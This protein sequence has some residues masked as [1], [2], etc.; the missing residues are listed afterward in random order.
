[1]GLPA[2]AADSLT[3]LPSPR[4]GSK[5]KVA[6]D[7]SKG[8]GKGESKGKEAPPV[9]PFAG[10]SGE[11]SSSSGGGRMAAAL[12]VESGP[13]IPG[14]LRSGA[15]PPPPVPP[16]GFENVG[17]DITA[18]AETKGKGKGGGES[19]P[20]RTLT[21]AQLADF[22]LCIDSRAPGFIPSRQG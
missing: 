1:M 12:A 7:A 3:P 13:P 9:N 10:M 17:G 22:N 21:E 14:T 18:D 11:A 20:R 4:G 8:S 16:S 2:P 5:G 19:Q 15:V 6:A